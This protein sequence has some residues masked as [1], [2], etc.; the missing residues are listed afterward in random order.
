MER[1]GDDDNIVENEL[2]DCEAP[3]L[4]SSVSLDHVGELLMH[5]VAFYL[6]GDQS[7]WI[8]LLLE[9][10]RNTLPLLHPTLRWV[11]PY[12][13]V[14]IQAWEHW[15]DQH[16]SEN[17]HPRAFPN[18]Q[19]MRIA[20]SEGDIKT[21]G[22]GNM[23]FFHSPHERPVMITTCPTKDLREKLSRYGNKKTKWSFGRKIKQHI[24]PLLMAADSMEDSLLK[25]FMSLFSML[26]GRLLQTVNEIGRS[27]EV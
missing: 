1:N 10:M 21:L 27:D 5:P 20:F 4:N 3:I 24:F 6:N 22:N 19:G 13:P 7:F 25:L 18:N 14:L 2:G 16:V 23:S 11:C 9:Q 26:A 15:D 8:Y 12:D 17:D